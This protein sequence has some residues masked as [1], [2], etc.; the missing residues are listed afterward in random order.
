MFSPFD[1]LQISTLDKYYFLIKYNLT[2]HYQ[3]KCFKIHQVDR[4]KPPSGPILAH[5][6]YVL[7]PDLRYTTLGLAPD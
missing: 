4:I 2:K 1:F 3:I 5:A 6:P 7:H